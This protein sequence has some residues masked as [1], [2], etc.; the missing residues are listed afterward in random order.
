MAT[1]GETNLGGENFDN[2]LVNFCVRQ[3]LLK[4]GIDISY[5]PR[6]LLRL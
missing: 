4:T 6:A 3:F 2:T 1:G 5:K